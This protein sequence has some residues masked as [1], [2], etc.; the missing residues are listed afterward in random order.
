MARFSYCAQIRDEKLGIAVLCDLEC[1]LDI[2]LEW[3]AVG[4]LPT[5]NAVY[6]EGEN[7]FLGEPFTRQLAAAIAD[8]AE[9]E[10][11]AGGDLFDRVLERD[12]IYATGPF[13]HPTSKLARA[14]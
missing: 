9:D 8:Q 4:P 10:L 7:L 3:E 6:L 12:G 1:E 11:N 2:S 5:V 14:W 13:N